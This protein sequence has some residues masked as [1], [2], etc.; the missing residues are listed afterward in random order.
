MLMAGFFSYIV[1][2]ELRQLPASVRAPRVGEK[3]PEFTL[4]DQNDR[5]VSLQ[6]LLSSPVSNVSA[7]KPEAVLLIFYRG[8]W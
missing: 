8:F 1:F 5:Q 7:T 2:Y 4:P 6:D 3:A